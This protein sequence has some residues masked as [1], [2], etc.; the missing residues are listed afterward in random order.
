MAGPIKIITYNI[1]GLKRRF[2]D[3]SQLLATER[4]AVA[5][6]E[7]T[8]MRENQRAAIPGY[9]LYRMDG[10]RPQRGLALYVR[11][12]LRA[13]QATLPALSF[14]AQ[15]V[16]IRVERKNQTQIMRVVRMEKQPRALNRCVPTLILY[17]FRCFRT[18]RGGRRLY[19]KLKLNSN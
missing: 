13:S 2:L 3:F 8:L 16:Y 5:G 17:A 14:E 1:L 6:L 12:D 11:S 9:I 19:G 15:A 10:V 7:E 18:Y 4:L